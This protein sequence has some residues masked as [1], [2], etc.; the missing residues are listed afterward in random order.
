MCCK[1]NRVRWDQRIFTPRQSFTDGSFHNSSIFSF[2]L[3]L[4]NSQITAEILFPYP[5]T[6]RH[7][8]MERVSLDSSF[9]KLCTWTL[10]YSLIK[11]NISLFLKNV[12]LVLEML[13]NSKN[14]YSSKHTFRFKNKCFKIIWIVFLFFYFN[15]VFFLINCFKCKIKS[16]IIFCLI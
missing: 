13:S 14:S 6:C 4:S 1:Y 15:S 8:D 12:S 11:T 7:R 16:E 2:H 5:H 9:C 3:Q 10:L